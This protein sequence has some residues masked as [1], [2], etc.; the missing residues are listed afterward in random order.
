MPQIFSCKLYF[1]LRNG[2]N[3]YKVPHMGKDRLIR[4]GRL[5][6]QLECSKELVEQAQAAIA[7]S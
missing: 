4:E 6:V 1:S 5:P 7:E 3:D 2:S